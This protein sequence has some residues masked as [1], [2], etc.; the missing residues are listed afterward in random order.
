MPSPNKRASN[1]GGDN[2]N[3]DDDEEDEEQWKAEMEIAK[4]VSLK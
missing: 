3:F 2:L 4:Q 1:I